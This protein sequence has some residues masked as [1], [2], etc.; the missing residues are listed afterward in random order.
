M[1]NASHHNDV[2]VQLKGG[3]KAFNRRG[4]RGSVGLNHS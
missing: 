2:K 1:I 3:S 4:G